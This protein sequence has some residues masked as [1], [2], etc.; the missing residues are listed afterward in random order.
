MSRLI[1]ISVFL[2]L[3]TVLHVGAFSV[4]SHNGDGSGGGQMGAASVTLA[5]A[6]GAVAELVEVWQRPPDTSLAPRALTPP[7]IIKTAQPV[8]N[9]EQQPNPPALPEMAALPDV[10]QPPQI[11][12]RLPALPVP[13]QAPEPPLKQPETSQQDAPDL[14][15]TTLDDTP[16]AKAPRAPQPPKS[17]V[18]PVADRPT[19]P[20]KPKPA[21]T[22]PQ[23]ATKA[24]GS[25][26]SPV[27][28]Q[29]KRKQKS[30]TLSKGQRNALLAKWGGKIKSRVRR[31]QRYPSGASGSGRVKLRVTVARNGRLAAVAVRGS[32]GNRAFD[33]AALKAVRRAGRFPKAPN[34]LTKA[35][36]SFTL[37]LTFNR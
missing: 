8:P 13:V 17:P 22:P 16:R 26:N 6:P 9:S 35:Q 23:K 1:E 20:T 29:P 36:Y 11:D 37:T 25:G 28:G 12:T 30:A 27:I 33:K 21:P 19:K 3:A 18:A 24:A 15:R 4:A 2:G 7:K 31:Y 14:A 10:P 34:G 5:A 32:S